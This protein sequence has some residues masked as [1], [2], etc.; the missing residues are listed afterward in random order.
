MDMI[1]EGADVAKAV[2]EFIAQ[3][4]IDKLVVGASRGG[5]VRYLKILKHCSNKED[6][7]T[8]GSYCMHTTRSFRNLDISANI[9]KTVPDFCTAYVISKGKPSSVKNAIRPAPAVSPLRIQLQKQANTDRPNQQE[10][11]GI[12]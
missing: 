6:I 7:N 10:K 1:L 2:V 11:K 5:F 12:L 9:Y 3:S 4:G 8:K